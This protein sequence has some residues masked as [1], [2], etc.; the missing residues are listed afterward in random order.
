MMVTCSMNDREGWGG[1]AYQVRTKCPGIEGPNA[2]A[3]GDFEAKEANDVR[4]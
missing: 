2:V 3:Y 4:A 1:T